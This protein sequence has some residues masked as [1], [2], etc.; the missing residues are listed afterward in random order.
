MVRLIFFKKIVINN[1][2]LSF[3]SLNGA[4]NIIVFS[5]NRAD[6]TG[7]NSLNGAINI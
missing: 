1:L 5:D 2:N 7:F 4:I 3:N 6:Y